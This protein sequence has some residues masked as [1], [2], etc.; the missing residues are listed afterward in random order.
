VSNDLFWVLQP[1][2]DELVRLQFLKIL[3]WPT[4]DGGVTATAKTQPAVVNGKLVVSGASSILVP[5]WARPENIVVVFAQDESGD[6]CTP[7][8]VPTCTPIVSGQLSGVARNIDGNWFLLLT[9]SLPVS[10]T[11]QIVWRAD[12]GV[13]E[14]TISLDNL[15]SRPRLKGRDN[16]SKLF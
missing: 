3:T 4:F 14:K 1:Q 6:T 2:L 7:T 13:P 15:R 12:V 9:W 11:R 16:G 8:C 5:M 10:G